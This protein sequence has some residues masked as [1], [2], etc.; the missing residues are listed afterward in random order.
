M[1]LAVA[2]RVAVAVTLA[3][4]LRVAVA[5]M[6]AVAEVLKEEIGLTAVIAPPR[7]SRMLPLPRRRALRHLNLRIG[8]LTLPRRASAPIGYH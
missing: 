2:L 6:A 8:P 7:L 3:V 4:A 5:V 1:T